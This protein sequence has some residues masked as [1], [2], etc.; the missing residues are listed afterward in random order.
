MGAEACLCVVDVADDV[1]CDALR[2]VNS[3]GCF[4]LFQGLAACGECKNE[5]EYCE[6]EAAEAPFSSFDTQFCGMFI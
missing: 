2:N 5:V 1:A 6:E 3:C 4:L